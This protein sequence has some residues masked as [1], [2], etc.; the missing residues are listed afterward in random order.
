VAAA[1]SAARC[2]VRRIVL[3]NDGAWLG[4]QFT[5]EGLGA[6]DE[7]TKYRD[8]RT[9]FPRSGL[10]LEIMNMIEDDNRRKYGLRRPGN[11]FCAWT[12]CEPRDTELLFRKLIGPYLKSGGGPIE[13][14]ENVEPSHVTVEKNRIVGV[15]FVVRGVADP[16]ITLAYRPKLTI[17]A[18]DW[19]DVV[20]LSGANYFCGP[21]LKDRFDEPSAP[22]SY[23]EVERNEIN[24][25][26][27]CLV[28]KESSSPT[29]IDRPKH[30]DERRYYAATT[31]TREEF[32]AFGWPKEAMRPFA[33][34]W[35]DTTLPNGPY[36]DGPT[37]YHHR[38]L[39]DRRHNN[40]PVGSEKVLVNW[41]LQD[42][43]TNRY[44]QHVVDELER[45]E[46]GAAKKNLVEMTP[47]QRRVV[48]D[49]A[50]RHALGLLYH[51]QTT[52]AERDLKAAGGKPIVTFRDLE[53]TNEF[54]TPDRLP[55]KPY[56]REGLRTD[57]L[58]M[59]R[60]QD[61]RDTDG[62]QCWAATMASDGLFGFQFNI[63]FH[64]TKRIFQN[65]DPRE[66]WTLVHTKHRNWHTD[67]DRAMVPL[68]SFVPREMNGLIV[69]GKNLGVSSIVQ[70]ALRLH[71]HG[72]L[73]G[74][75]AGTIASICLSKN[76][77][78]REI[79]SET[80]HVREVQ[81][82]L[83]EPIDGIRGPKPPGVLIWPYHDV[84][85]DA[86]FFAAANWA[87]ISGVYVAGDSVPDFDADQVVTEPERNR[88][89]EKAVQLGISRSALHA[90]TRRE[91]V[92]ALF[93]VR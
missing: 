19:G 67:T 60:E 76:L 83:L 92:R 49:D 64:P 86:D 7:W 25:I 32:Q 26:T 3:A 71:G 38:R 23:D 37:V 90:T 91:L 9:W 2:G 28:L 85:P 52:V 87:A 44:P 75:A 65:D 10:F 54:G 63:D 48:F 40:L 42:Y 11:C 27:Y 5:S 8:G 74:Q 24:P 6:V 55:P 31:A 69:A 56:V 20:R 45:L 59:L 58:Y 66:A 29:I 22:T 46:P 81:R 79:A 72:M 36:T 77:A 73:A 41:P 1:I 61:V 57:C 70:S 34:A 82:L 68:R 16:P 18:S 62:N 4:G 33:P 50:K 35:R 17:D 15:E 30:Y 39:V 53:L 14:V 84:P 89:S 88:A 13:L 43:P 12:T 93:P 47:R 51:L 80:R 78:P 21:D